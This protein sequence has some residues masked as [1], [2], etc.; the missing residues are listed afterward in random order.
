M[1]F[2]LKDC[3]C[4]WSLKVIYSIDLYCIYSGNYFMSH[5]IC[6]FFVGIRKSQENGSKSAGVHPDGA[7]AT[8]VFIINEE[9][10]PW[11]SLS[12]FF[13][14]WGKKCVTFIFPAAITRPPRQMNSTASKPPAEVLGVGADNVQLA[15]CKHWGPV[16]W[17]PPRLKTQLWEARAGS[18]QRGVRRRS[19]RPCKP[20]RRIWFPE[21]THHTGTEC[22]SLMLSTL[23]IPPPVRLVQSRG[24]Q[25]DWLSSLKAFQ[26]VTSMM[27][28]TA[29][30]LWVRRLYGWYIRCY[31]LSKQRSFCL[32]ETLVS[33]EFISIFQFDMFY[34]LRT[35]ELL[36]ELS[37]CP[38]RKY[39]LS[40]VKKKYVLLVLKIKWIK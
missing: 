2:T 14:C 28:V 8:P 19:R 11:I 34:P 40:I 13:G 16:R 31:H 29:V 12:H 27:S 20:G 35:Q 15:L 37:C 3:C 32:V 36:W 38:I 33:T 30:Q 10:F 9:E 26:E 7:I 39:I 5:R 17:L 4:F 1:C 25:L 24:V 22:S 18:H 21:S 23:L 6:R